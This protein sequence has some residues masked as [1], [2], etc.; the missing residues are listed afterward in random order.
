[1]SGSDLFECIDCCLNIGAVDGLDHHM[2]A[3]LIEERDGARD[4]LR[5]A[6]A[7]DA[8]PPSFNAGS[9][10]NSSR[11]LFSSRISASE[12]LGRTAIDA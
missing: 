11:I 1:M 8:M 10:G 2:P 12:M 4:F 3:M 9:S 5:V 7:D 6:G